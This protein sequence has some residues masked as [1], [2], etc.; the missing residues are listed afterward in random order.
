MYDNTYDKIKFKLYMD[1]GLSLN[2]KK[3]V[4]GLFQSCYY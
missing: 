4:D 2:F 3:V 1:I